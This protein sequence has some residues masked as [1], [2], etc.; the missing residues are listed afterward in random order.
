VLSR[1]SSATAVIATV[2]A[3][4]LSACG[5]SDDKKAD[6]EPTKTTSASPSPTSPA[7]PRGADGVT[8]EIQNWDAHADDPAVLAWKQASEA[9]MASANERKVLPGMR[10]G[11]AKPLLR[12]YV[13]NLRVAWKKKWHVTTKVPAKIGTTDST[14]DTARLVVCVWAPAEGLRTK[15][16]ALVAK[17]DDKWTRKEVSVRSSGG[18]WVV[19]KVKVSGTCPGGAPA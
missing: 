12:T 8:I 15:G 4:T 17:T 14:A 18:R 7:Q 13:R 2:L 10:K 3:L 9:F 19:T 11:F 6:P 16:G 5:G 1:H